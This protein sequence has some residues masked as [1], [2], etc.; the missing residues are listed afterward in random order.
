MRL[1]QER[2]RRLGVAPRPWKENVKVCLKLPEVAMSVTPPV[3]ALVVENGAWPE[4]ALAGMTSEVGMVNAV[5][6]GLRV[7]SVVAA[8]GVASETRQVPETPGVRT[9]GAQDRDSGATREMAAERFAAPR[10]A[11]MTAPCEVAIA[12]VEAVNAADAAPAG[13]VKVAGTVNSDGRL[14][15]R[16]SDTPPAGAA[17]ERVTVHGVTAFETRLAAAQ[18][19]PE[20]VGG[21]DRDRVAATDEPFFVAVTVTV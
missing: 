10:V 6:S 15:E 3:R 14:L 4:V 18:L 7:T 11:V 16:E 2:E 20:R 5:L 13:M 9:L 19:R 1:A 21:D 12:D 17:L 8:A